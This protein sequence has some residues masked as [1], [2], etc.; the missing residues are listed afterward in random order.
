M[1]SAEEWGVIELSLRVA[2]VATLWSVPVA[3]ALA[4]LLARRNF[5]GKA[6]VDALVY[7]PLV[8]PPVVLGY[9]LLV[10]FGRKGPIGSLLQSW[11]GVTLAFTWEG[12]ALAAGIA[13]LPLAVRA[14]RLSLDAVD[15]KL[16]QAAR[17]LGARRSRVFWTIT[18]PLAMPGVLAGAILSF[19]RGLGEFGATITFVSDIPGET[20]TLSLAVHTLLQAP[21]GEAAAVRLSIIAVV[22]AMAALMASEY[23]SRRLSRR[24][25]LAKGG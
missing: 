1:L 2:L 6:L 3:V 5:P 9:G 25:G 24:L 20:R 7:L 18:L 19:A 8:L 22:V 21:D 23:L 16:E 13:G 12:A 15:R 14:V 10:L 4:W 11:F 17:T